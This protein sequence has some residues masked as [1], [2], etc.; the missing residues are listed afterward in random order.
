MRQL[1]ELLMKNFGTHALNNYF[2]IFLKLEGEG[3]DIRVYKIRLKK[4][5]KKKRELKNQP[6]KK[7][8]K[9]EKN[10]KEEWRLKRPFHKRDARKI[11]RPCLA[12]KREFLVGNRERSATREKEGK[13]EATIENRK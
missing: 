13:R 6:T 9:D 5:E 4:T 10:G 7:K 1:G 3:I 11:R 12:K 2:F 8:Q